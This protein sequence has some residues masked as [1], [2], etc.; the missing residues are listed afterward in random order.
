MKVKLNVSKQF[1][2]WVQ[3]DPTDELKCRR[4]CPPDVCPEAPPSVLT[5][6]ALETG[7]S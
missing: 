2:I 5:L 1:Q 4:P 6:K 7:L 3:L